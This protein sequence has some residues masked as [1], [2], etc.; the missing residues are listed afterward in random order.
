MF[1]KL[2]KWNTWMMGT[3]WNSVKGYIV[4]KDIIVVEGIVSPYAWIQVR[5]V[6]KYLLKKSSQKLFSLWF[7]PWGIV[8]Y[9]KRDVGVIKNSILV[10]RVESSSETIEPNF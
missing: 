2:K 10:K 7:I 3:V 5:I 6:K 9:I 8:R 1:K 4:N